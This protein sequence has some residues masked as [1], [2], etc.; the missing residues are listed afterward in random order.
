M[1]KKKPSDADPDARLRDFSDGLEARQEAFQA[2]LFDKFGGTLRPM[3]QIGIRLPS[4]ALRYLLRMN[5][6]PFGRSYQY[7]GPS[8]SAKSAFLYETYRWF[9]EAGGRYIHIETE[10]K[11]Q[12][13]LRRSV[14]RYP[15]HITD[16]NWVFRAGTMQD[17]QTVYWAQAR[18]MKAQCKKFNVGRRVPFVFGI[19]SLQAKLSNR[20]HEVYEK[21]DGA[22]K[23]QFGN[24][25]NATSSW[26]KYAT[27]VIHGWPMVV[28]GVNHDKV[29]KDD[30][31][32]DVHHAPGGASQKYMA[33]TRILMQHVTHLKRTS[34]GTEGVLIDMQADKNS[35]SVTGQRIRVEFKWRVDEVGVQTSWWDWPKTTVETLWHLIDRK[36]A[37]QLGR[38]LDARLGLRHKNA[39]AYTCKALGV[40][41]PVH[42]SELGLMI[43]ADATLSADL[44]KLLEVRD[45]QIWVPGQSDLATLMPEGDGEGDDG[46]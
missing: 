43:E 31:G 14:T 44:D 4:L 33:T 36:N 42:P 41:D 29:K 13:L 19:D 37:G 6:F 25:A 27:N 1:A 16:K 20:T 3:P 7:Y 32:N 18:E 40:S 39:A 22:Y 34:D 30:Y 9:V 21:S 23:P 8:A 35:A 26:L 11:D 2:G 15:A 28:V 10:D 24:E 5:I 12:E 45:Y 46:A 17:Y 38:D